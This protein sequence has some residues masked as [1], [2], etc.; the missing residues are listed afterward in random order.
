[1]YDNMWLCIICPLYLTEKSTLKSISI[2]LQIFTRISL[3]AIRNQHQKGSIYLYHKS[4]SLSMNI[5][6]FSL[7][8]M[9]VSGTNMY[10]K[11]VGGTNMYHPFKKMVNKAFWTLSNSKRS[12]LSVVVAFMNILNRKKD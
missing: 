12:K 11:N 4:Y 5:L 2:E 1:M 8:T 6:A 10:H 3:N 9:N 7:R